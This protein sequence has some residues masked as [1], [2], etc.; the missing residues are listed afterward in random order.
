[1]FAYYLVP[2]Y[3]LSLQNIVISKGNENMKPLEILEICSQL[4]G[5][6]KDLHSIGYTHNDIKPDNVMITWSF[7]T[8]S[9][10]N[11]FGNL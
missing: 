10:E 3:E 4:V 2:K 6:L 8:S 11:N 7:D 1:M 9:S 5:S